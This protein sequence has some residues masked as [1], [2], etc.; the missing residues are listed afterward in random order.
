VVL[1]PAGLGWREHC[2]GEVRRHRRSPLFRRCRRLHSWTNRA[3]SV[4]SEGLWM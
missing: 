1:A 2:I 4:D 3:C